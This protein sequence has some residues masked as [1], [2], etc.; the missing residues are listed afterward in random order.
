MSIIQVSLGLHFLQL[1]RCV[2]IKQNN[3]CCLAWQFALIDFQLVHAFAGPLQL[4]S[5]ATFREAKLLLRATSVMDPERTLWAN[6][7]EDPQPCPGPTCATS[8]MFL[9]HCNSVTK[10][11]YD[12]CRGPDMLCLYRQTLIFMRE[13]QDWSAQ[14]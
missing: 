9:G 6:G 7:L 4:P 10:L 2:D 14:Q 12:T 3:N 11:Q 8:T 1:P 13:L 5:A